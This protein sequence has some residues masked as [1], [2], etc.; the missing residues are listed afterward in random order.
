MRDKK[1]W[2]GK[3]SDLFIDTHNNLCSIMVGLT[4]GEL[5]DEEIKLLQDSGIMDRLLEIG[6]SYGE[7][8]WEMHRQENKDEKKVDFTI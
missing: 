7:K 8:Y 1:A 2:Y 3:R 4:D 5:T 6:E